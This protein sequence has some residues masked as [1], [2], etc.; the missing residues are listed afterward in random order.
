MLCR[1]RA[2]SARCIGTWRC[3]IAAALADQLQ[4]NR[5]R[6]HTDGYCI[7]PTRR[8]VRNQIIFLKDHSHRSR[9]ECFCQL[10]SCLWHFF[11]DFFQMFHVCHM[12]DQ[13]I[14]RRP[15]L[16]L[17][18]LSGRLFV[19]AIPTKT[20]DGLRRKCHKSSA[21]QDLTRPFQRIQ[22]HILSIYFDN[23]C[24]QCVHLTFISVAFQTKKINVPI[25]RHPLI[26]YNVC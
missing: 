1:G 19:K 9:P 17:I 18:N 25:A 13:R 23:F 2:G 5:I 26:C 6:W 15:S 7:K 3:N 21:F 11:H 20:V 14:I 4:C 16:C 24:L 10:V 8:S 12:N 22:I